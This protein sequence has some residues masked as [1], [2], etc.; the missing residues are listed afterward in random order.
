MNASVDPCDDFY[1]YAC[2]N[3]Q[4]QHQI[5]DDAASV[6]NWGNLHQN[7]ELALKGWFVRDKILKKD[8][9]FAELLAEDPPADGSSINESAVKKAKAFYNMCL[10][11]CKEEAC[12]VKHIG[13]IAKELWTM[14]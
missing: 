3:W 9:F 7:L 6:S 11:E 13:C 2:G 4:K 8:L 10:N 14:F 1:E 12:F 5:P